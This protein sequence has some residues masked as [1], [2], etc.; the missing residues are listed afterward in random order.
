MVKDGSWQGK[1]SRAR[2]T[3]RR[4]N[5]RAGLTAKAGFPTPDFAVAPPSP[6]FAAAPPSPCLAT[7][8][9]SVAAPPSPGLTTPWSSVAAAPSPG[10]ATSLSV[11]TN[12]V[13]LPHSLE[14]D[15][16]EEVPDIADSRV[17]QTD[18]DFDAGGTTNQA[19]LLN[20]EVRRTSCT[21][22]AKFSSP[23]LAANFVAA[24]PQGVGVLQ[25]SSSSPDVV[26]MHFAYNSSLP[27]VVDLTDTLIS[28]VSDTS[29]NLENIAST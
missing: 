13:S 3:A 11:A 1:P 9:S 17:L 6:G 8:S 28:W 4:A 2:R 20:V 25:I 21:A 19:G 23:A 5:E 29:C 12:A 16:F 15:P 7:S 27:S 22:L 26:Y 10:L 18:G 14:Y 24:P